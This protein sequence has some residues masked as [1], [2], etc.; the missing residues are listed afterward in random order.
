MQVNLEC[1]KVDYLENR[2]SRSEVLGATNGSRYS[3]MDQVKSV[4]GSLTWP[5][6]EYPDPN[7]IFWGF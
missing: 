3:I 5:I 6:L 2:V 1:R 7:V 4:E